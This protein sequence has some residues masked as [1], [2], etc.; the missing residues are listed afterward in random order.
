MALSHINL[1]NTFSEK[2]RKQLSLK[3]NYSEKRP[4]VFIN[5][6]SKEG[7]GTALEVR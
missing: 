2:W 3:Y 6:L 4:A 7:F 1:A 5:H